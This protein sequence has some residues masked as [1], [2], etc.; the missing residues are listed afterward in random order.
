LAGA[1][2]IGSAQRSNALDIAA[3]DSYAKRLHIFSTVSAGTYSEPDLNP[4]K[5]DGLFGSL[6]HAP[7]FAQVGFIVVL[8]FIAFQFI[9]IGFDFLFPLNADRARYR[10]WKRWRWVGLGLVLL[11]LLS[12][13]LVFALGLGL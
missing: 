13:S 4:I 12:I 5:R 9:P 10:D 6:G 3:T 2:V 8:G 11:G 1:L 7:L